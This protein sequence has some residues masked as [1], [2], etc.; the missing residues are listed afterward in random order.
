MDESE[1][2]K[3]AEAHGQ[4][5]VAGDMKA[6]GADLDKSAYGAAGEVMKQMPEGLSASEVT[7][8]NIEGDQA[9]VTIRY[10]G[11]SGRADVESTWAERDGEPKIV[12]LRVL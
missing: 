11:S 4:A 10:T 9:V 6:A 3:R 2:R 8:V 5:T 1:I 12:G 7:N